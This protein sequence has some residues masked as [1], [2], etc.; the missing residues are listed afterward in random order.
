MHARSTID[1]NRGHTH[2]RNINKS[3]ITNNS[4]SN[5]NKSFRPAVPIVRC[6]K[7]SMTQAR[8]WGLRLSHRCP[9]PPN[10]KSNRFHVAKLVVA[11]ALGAAGGNH[12][13]MGP[14]CREATPERRGGSTI[15]GS[16]MASLFRV[17]GN[18]SPSSCEH[19]GPNRRKGHGIACGRH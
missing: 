12:D 6:H 17:T 14:D 5:N 16:S 9:F 1:V 10:L 15:R 19:A 4:N 7:H 3:L 18:K 11:L 13:G 2:T 8:T